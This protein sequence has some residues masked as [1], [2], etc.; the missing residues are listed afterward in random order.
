MYN[1]GVVHLW[2]TGS[3][4]VFNHYPLPSVMPDEVCTYVHVWAS[5]NELFTYS[6]P[7]SGIGDRTAC[8]VPLNIPVL[9]EIEVAI[10]MQGWGWLKCFDCTKGMGVRTSKQS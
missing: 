1:A 4:S 5:S 9:S 8:Y 2:G 3:D 6:I 7:T 10:S